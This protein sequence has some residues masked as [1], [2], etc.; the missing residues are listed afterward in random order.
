MFGDFPPV[1]A[2]GRLVWKTEENLLDV[3]LKQRS[4]HFRFRNIFYWYTKAVIRRVFLI[5]QTVVSWIY[6]PVFSKVESKTVGVLWSLFFMDVVWMN[7]DKSIIHQEAAYKHRPRTL[8][9]EIDMA[10]MAK[11]DHAQL[12]EDHFI[13]LHLSLAHHLKGS[14]VILRHWTFV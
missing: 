9:E 6:V 7:L 12:Q 5:V 13:R 3:V 8:H 1:K 14:F 11:P 10:D 4:E 2:L